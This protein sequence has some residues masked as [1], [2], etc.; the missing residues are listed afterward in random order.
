M[1]LAEL[2]HDITM[3]VGYP[4][5]QF[6]QLEKKVTKDYTLEPVFQH[7]SGLG[8]PAHN[9]HRKERPNCDK[10]VSFDAKTCLLF[11]PVPGNLNLYGRSVIF[12][13]N[14]GDLDW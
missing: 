2:G 3:F 10:K 12:P 7:S 14:E 5:H 6:T 9:C 1:K 8:V 11:L 13:D 4:L